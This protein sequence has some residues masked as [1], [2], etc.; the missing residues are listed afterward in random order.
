MAAEFGSRTDYFPISEGPRIAVT[1]KDVAKRTG[2]SIATISKYLN[3][4]NVLEQN[5]AA[6]AVAI[7][8]LG[9]RVNEIARGL[10]SSRSMTVGVLIPNLE[11]VFCTSIVANIENILQQSGYSTIICD[12]REDIGLEREKLE[13]LANKMVDGFIYMP[14]GNQEK[15]VSSLVARNMPV[16]LI[17]R[18]LPG[19]ACD[20][21]LV[22]NL[23][24]S[25]NAVEHLIV[26]GH[27]RIG[28]IAGPEDI[29]TA[30]ERLKGYRRVHKDYDIAVD[31]DL[32]LEGDYSLK[33][34]Y[35]LMEDFLKRPLPPSAVFVTNYEMTLGAIMA[36][37]ESHLSAPDDIS[38]IGFDNLQL[39]KIVKP[40]LSIVVQPIQSI[41]E[42]AATLL[43]R[44]MKDD[45]TG[46][47]AIHRLKTELIIGES[48]RSVS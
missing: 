14:L 43:L 21:V 9:F 32:V 16:I 39:A 29:Y 19:V 24:A 2:L 47:P 27:R 25:Y 17:D 30:Q 1:I 28:F 3:G 35:L 23:N 22:D 11:N 33:S 38:I 36:L 13:F 20:T 48:V 46:F 31:D 15:F 4:G 10:K 37:N 41:G 6:I 44:R 26:L 7:D 12:Y 5:R 42:T 34:G 40:S 45:Q 8:D 18:P